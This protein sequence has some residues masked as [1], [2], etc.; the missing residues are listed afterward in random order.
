MSSIWNSCL[1]R[2]ENE[3]STN[4]LNTWIRPLQ[5][6]EES[7]VIKLLAPNQFIIAHVKEHFLGKI[8]DAIYEFSS[9]Q[10]TVKMVIGS[11][12]VKP[13][14]ITNRSTRTTGLAREPQKK[15]KL[16]TF[17][18]TA[19]TFENFVE[20]KSNQLAKAASLQVSENIGKA[21][22]PLLIYGAS[23]LGKTH[24]MHA[25]GNAILAKIPMQILF[26]Y[27]RKNLFRIWLSL[28]SKI[29]LM[30]SKNIIAML[31]H[32]LLMISSFSPEKNALRRNFFILLTP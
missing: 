11:K 9:G 14:I 19:F 8:E 12:N 26:I 22:N 25:I 20:G 2:L 28:S 6:Q 1:S 7:D 18:N 16:P 4:D 32:Y 3:I 17:I 31:M 24:L 21:Y 29:A 5:A 13:A 30:P 15:K 10:Y 23:G 27:T